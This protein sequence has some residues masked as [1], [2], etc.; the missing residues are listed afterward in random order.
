VR[1][2]I[3]LVGR[4][5]GAARLPSF[6]PFSLPPARE[7]TIAERGE[8][9]DVEV[10]LA[11]LPMT[12]WLARAAGTLAGNPWLAG[13]RV[14]IGK[15]RTGTVRWEEGEWILRSGAAAST[16]SR[17]APP[18]PLP[19]R[20]TLGLLSTREPV[21]KLPAALYRL[22]RGERGLELRA[23]PG[24][25][26]LPRGDARPAGGP[27]SVA[28]LFE[29]SAPEA[30]APATK[31][32]GI[33]L[34]TGE[35]LLPPFPATATVARGG[36]A[37]RLPGEEMLRFAGKRPF[38]GERQGWQARAYLPGEGERTLELASGLDGELAGWAGVDLAAGAEVDLLRAAAER[39]EER[40]RGLPLGRIAGLE[41]A[42]LVELLGALQGCGWS[43]L[44]VRSDPRSVRWQI[45][46]GAA[47]GGTDQPASN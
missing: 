40:F 37:K 34:W 29:R 41:P 10:R 25:G 23:G 32:E 46:P 2:W 6:G 26:P 5:E 11:A 22:V 14:R 39:V 20:A 43:R 15:G 3:A 9:G 35:S 42:R 45:C 8:G 1:R 47:S 33:V 27:A 21:W 31:I 12:R 44:V 28:W 18:D 36:N 24:Q 38:R 7:L 13:G 17:E 4:G 30:G 16:G 19:Q